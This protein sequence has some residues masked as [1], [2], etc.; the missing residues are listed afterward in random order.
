[1]G[2]LDVWSART[3]AH[4]ILGRWSD[5]ADAA[6]L[7]AFS[8]ALARGRRRTRARAVSRY[9]R[10]GADG[11]LQIISDPP[12]VVPAA[13]LAGT[14]EAQVRTWAAHVLADYRRTLPHDLQVLL[15]G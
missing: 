6:H 10:A 8:A 9:T 12:F 5:G 4:D 13:S 15:D 3:S 11:Q 1:M 7:Q 2:R 14:S